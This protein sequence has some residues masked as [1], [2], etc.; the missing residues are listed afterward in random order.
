MKRILLLLLALMLTVALASCGNGEKTPDETID[1][2]ANSVR[3][4][5]PKTETQ[6]PAATTAPKPTPKPEDYDYFHVF[7]APEGNPRDI[8]YD[9]MYAMSQVKWTAGETWTTTW[10]VQGDFGVNLTYEKGKT[11]YGI[12]YSNTKATLDEFL[13]YLPSNGRFVP[14][15]PWFEELVGNHCS[16]SMDM[17]F[18]QILDFPYSGTLKPS[19]SREGLLMFPEGL[20]KPPSRSE[21]NPDDYISNTMFAHNGQD[22]IYAGYAQL[23]KGDILYKSI[24]GSGHTRMVSK[25]EI[26][27]SVAGKMMPARSYVYCL[28]QTNAWAD[29][30]KESTWFID[31][32]YSFSTL[33]DTLF[34]PVTFCIYHDE[35]AKIEDAY[36]MMKGKNTP[37]SV[38]KMLNGTVESTFPLTYVRLTVTDVNGKTV[39]EHMEYDLAKSYK[40]NLRNFTFKLNIDDLPAGEYTLKT[41]AAIA[42]GGV[43][44]E[45]VK[46]T[47]S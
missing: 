14:N 1:P 7:K 9:Y 3:T 2:L 19:T 47:V 23:G 18:Q 15:S 45:T 28:E 44:L 20:E 40:I 25:V 33:Y 36:V 4:E 39:A 38:L 41:R 32:K 8:V 5:G 13:Q 34:M 21:N 46:F 42:R 11:Y 17:A 37:E 16:S 6:K 43:D 31:R 22:A 27:K 26:S 35:N 29:S 30:K 12:P 24:D 10:K